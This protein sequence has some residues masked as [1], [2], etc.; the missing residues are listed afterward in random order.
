MVTQ[1][2]AQVARFPVPV[3]FD[4]EDSAMLSRLWGP[5]ADLALRYAAC[6]LIILH[7]LRNRDDASDASHLVDERASTY[8]LLEPVS[9]PSRA[10]DLVDLHRLQ[11]S[12]T[13]PR[14]GVGLVH[15]GS[16]LNCPYW[17]VI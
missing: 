11:K 5:P 17:D 2:P 15:L 12:S 10:E 9:H 6:F 14:Q 4:D 16:T 1:C 7:A 3:L 8:R 13:K